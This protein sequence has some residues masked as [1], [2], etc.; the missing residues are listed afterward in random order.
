MVYGHSM[1]PADSY[2]PVMQLPDAKVTKN[3][4]LLGAE[5]LLS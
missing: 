2:R 3:T 1:P 4:C 5:F